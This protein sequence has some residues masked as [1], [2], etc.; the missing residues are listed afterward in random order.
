M[1]RVVQQGRAG[2]AGARPGSWWVAMG[3]G[4]VAWRGLGSG[5]T[6][7]SFGRHWVEAGQAL[8]RDAHTTATGFQR[9]ELNFG[10]A[11]EFLAADP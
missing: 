6:S 2:P 5:E 8:R 3:V 4:G 1:F 11:L 7:H 9:I 10:R